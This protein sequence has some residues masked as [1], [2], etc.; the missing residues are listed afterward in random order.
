ML[1]VSSPEAIKYIQFQKPFFK[2][3]SR[4]LNIHP[5][6]THVGFETITLDVIE[7]G[8]ATDRQI[9]K[10]LDPFIHSTQLHF[11]KFI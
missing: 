6:L 4:F 7:S 2:D 5:V 3:I 11:S 1:S 9:I 10:I 8:R